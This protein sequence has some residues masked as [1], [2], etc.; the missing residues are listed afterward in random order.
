MVFDCYGKTLRSG[1]V[2]DVNSKLNA[3]KPLNPESTTKSA[4]VPK[5]M[6]NPATKVI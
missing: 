5:I 3:F 4:A 6:P 1:S 2:N